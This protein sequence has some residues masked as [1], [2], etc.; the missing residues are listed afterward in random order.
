MWLTDL[1]V[2]PAT[3][4]VYLAG[5]VPPAQVACRFYRGP[6]DHL[7]GLDTQAGAG[8]RSMSMLVTR[9]T[10]CDEPTRRPVVSAI[11]PHAQPLGPAVTLRSLYEPAG[12]PARARAAVANVYAA[13]A[14]LVL[15]AGVYTLSGSV[16]LGSA[17]EAG[18]RRARRAARSLSSPRRSRRGEA[19]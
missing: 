14:L 5:H 6:F 17:F 3:G 18:M 19:A 8:V 1:P 11:A 16:V 15:L 9:Q 12:R 7:L 10:P 4:F 2:R 13:V